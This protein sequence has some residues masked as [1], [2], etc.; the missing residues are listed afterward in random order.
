MTSPLIDCWAKLHRGDAHRQTLDVEMRRVLEGDSRPAIDIA[1]QF[2]PETS[3][4]LVVLGQ[5]ANVEH[6][7]L[8]LGDVLQNYRAALDYLVCRLVIHNQR[9][10]R[11]SNMWIAAANQ[12]WWDKKSGIYL[13]GVNSEHIKVIEKYQPKESGEGA[14]WHP[15]A[16]LVRLSNKDKHE[17]VTPLL[18]A[19]PGLTDEAFAYGGCEIDRVEPLFDPSAGPL[20]PGTELLRLRLRNVEPHHY[21]EMNTKFPLTPVLEDGRPLNIVLHQIRTRIV[22]VLSEFERIL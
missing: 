5:V 21:V 17:V 18:I 16:T 14:D 15:L 6:V 13:A 20:K 11:R 12:D 22:N 7:G 3:S 2:E 1:F 4:Y 8:V 10:V 19:S 9:T